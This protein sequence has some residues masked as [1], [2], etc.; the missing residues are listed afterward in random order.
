ME[1]LK[2]N[3][4][5]K[6][7]KVKVEETSNGKM[8]VYC[9]EGSYEVETKGDMRKELFEDDSGEGYETQD[10]QIVKAPLTGTIVSINVKKGDKV[11]DGDSLVTL[12]A[13]KMEND[14]SSQKC[15]IIREVKV[16]KND[17]V[18]KGDVL[19]IID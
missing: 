6:E 16:K 1:D 8:R 10:K 13:M 18:N 9:D 5:G 7:H 3:I 2:I 17:N 19:V 11:K 14:I 15:G 4:D 12:V